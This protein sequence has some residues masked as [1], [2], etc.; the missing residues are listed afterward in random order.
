MMIL[1]IAVIIYTTLFMQAFTSKASSALSYRITQTVIEEPTPPYESILH[2]IR[3][4]MSEAGSTL[5]LSPTH[6]ITQRKISYVFI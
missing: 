2:S 4:I 1:F 3:N 5:P 6:T